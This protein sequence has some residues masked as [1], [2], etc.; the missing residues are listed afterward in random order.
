MF[1][2]L[3]LEMASGNTKEIGLRSDLINAS[4]KEI[5]KSE[6]RAALLKYYISEHN[7]F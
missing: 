7:N 3:R 5:H 6:I 2:K 1:I 4:L